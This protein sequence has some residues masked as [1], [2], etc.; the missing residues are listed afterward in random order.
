METKIDDTGLTDQQKV[1]AFDTLFDC[2]RVRVLGYAGGIDGK[3]IHHIGL[4][5]WTEFSDNDD[6][7]SREILLKFLTQ[8]TK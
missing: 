1:K 7:K 5:L 3:A 4:E 6:K 8:D 2:D